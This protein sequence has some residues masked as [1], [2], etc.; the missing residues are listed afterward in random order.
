M[1]LS[2]GTDAASVLVNRA[3]R[4]GKARALLGMG[5]SNAA[6]AAAL[7]T[8]IPTNFRYDVTAS[9]TG[10]NNT[11]WDQPTSQN[12]YTVG[13]SIQGNGSQ[14]P[15]EE[16]DSVLLG[17]G[18]PRAGAL[19][20]RDERQGHGEGAGWRHVRHRGRQPVGSDDGGRAVTAGIDARLIE[21]EAALKAGNAAG[22]M[23]ILNALRGAARR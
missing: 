22:M 8:G 9:L 16:R 10:G 3:A 13:D 5:L 12:R 6:A 14:H 20:A 18:P 7:V 4:I 19:Q 1:N 11:L 21:A 17:E 2:N 23:T 15:G